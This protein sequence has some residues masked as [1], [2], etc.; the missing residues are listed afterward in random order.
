MKYILSIMLLILSVSCTTTRT[1]RIAI[2]VRKPARITFPAETK[3]VLIVDNTMNVNDGDIGAKITT[4]SVKILLL[5]YL[6]KYMIG[7]H[8]FDNVRISSEKINNL[9]TSGEIGNICQID[10]VDA[11]IVLD[12]FSSSTQLS[13]YTKTFFEKMIVSYIESTFSVYYSDGSKISDFVHRDG[14][15]LDS[16]SK[17]Q[18]TVV[19][20]NVLVDKSAQK[21]ADNLTSMF[22]PSWKYEH[23]EFF[24]DNSSEMKDVSKCLDEEDWI[25]AA[26][27]WG[28]LYD[29]E[30]NRVKRMKLAYNLA[31]ASEY[32]DDI[33]NA[34]AWIN[35][36]YDLANKN[37]S[38]FSSVKH[39]RYKLETRYKEKDSLFEQLKIVSD[40]S[41]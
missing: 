18:D 29:K 33:E 41:D 1:G 15:Q 2:N 32:Y 8:F 35:I 37:D 3:N 25:G 21:V 23:R 24:S 30:Q 4:D 11:L 14:M 40:K 26:D 34:F 28:R 22:I 13:P 16:W 27:I 36:A 20:M 9:L 7:E 19:V 17:N 39:Y 12:S 6:Q 38:D 10:S 5:H 31:L